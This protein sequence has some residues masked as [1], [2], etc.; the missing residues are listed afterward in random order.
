MMKLHLKTKL[1]FRILIVM[2]SAPVFWACYPEEEKIQAEL[3]EDDFT[4]K[5]SSDPLDKA[6]FEFYNQYQSKLLYD[7]TEK[8]YNHRFI[9][10]ASTKYKI[11]LQKDRE[12]LVKGIEHLKK[13]FMAYYPE[14][15]RQ[16]Y[17]PPY[18]LLADSIRLSGKEL[19]ADAKSNTSF[20]ALG[21]VRTGIDEMSEAD[22]KKSKEE[23]HST[24]WSEYMIGVNK[25]TID[26]KFYEIS[27]DYYTDGRE[28]LSDISGCGGDAVIKLNKY[29]FWADSKQR[30]RPVCSDKPRAPSRVL[31]LYLF[32]KRIISTNENN[33]KRIL[34]NHLRLRQKYD[35]LI[36][37]FKDHYGVDLQ[38]IGNGTPQSEEQPTPTN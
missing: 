1:L 16:E 15:F 10:R 34:D 4:P 28:N 24:F 18:F 8:F 19:Y 5:D 21:R 25:L 32:I 35:I 17:F 13:H 36:A 23:L 14:S 9:F 31:D 3:G 11:V 27:S 20:V 33:M 30:K 7:F 6:V 26:S 22:L 38:S 37:Y 12:I 29:G 2:L